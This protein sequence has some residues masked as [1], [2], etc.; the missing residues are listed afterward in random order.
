MATREMSFVIAK[1]IVKAL[2][3]V[4]SSDTEGDHILLAG[5]TKTEDRLPSS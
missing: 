3:A 4:K 1:S 2:A 5:R